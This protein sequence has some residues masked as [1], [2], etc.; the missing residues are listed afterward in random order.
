VGQVRIAP[1][2]APDA[3]SRLLS[4]ESLGTRLV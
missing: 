2:A 1:G 4:G 3:L